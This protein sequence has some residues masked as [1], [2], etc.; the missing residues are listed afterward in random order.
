MVLASNDQLQRDFGSQ[1]RRP[2]QD[3]VAVRAYPHQG[4]VGR[5]YMVDPSGVVVFV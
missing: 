1:R 4:E 5:R 2:A 3:P